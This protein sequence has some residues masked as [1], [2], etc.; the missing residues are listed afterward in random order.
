[1]KGVKRKLTQR[2]LE[3]EVRRVEE[4]GISSDESNSNGEEYEEPFDDSGSS[5]HFSNE[6]DSDESVES[7]ILNLETEEPTTDPI[8]WGNGEEDLIVYD[9]TGSEGVK[10]NFDENNSPIDVFLT[11]FDETLFNKIVCWTNSKAVKVSKNL[12]RKS[13]MH[14]WKNVDKTELKKFLGLCIAMGNVQMP[15]IKCYWSKQEIYYHPLF[16]KTMGRNRFEM[17]LRCMCFYNENDDLSKRMHKISNITEHILENIRKVYYPGRN[18]SIDEALLLW[19]ERL[20]FRQYIPN[21]AAKY[22][23]KLYELCT[24]DGYVLN[25]II[26]SGKGTV[27]QGSRGHASSVVHEIMQPYLNKGHTIYV[28]NYYSSVELAE[29]MLRNRTHVVGTLRNN[30]KGNPTEVIGKKLKKGEY[31]WKRRENIV[32]GKWR[33]KRDV[34]VI[35]TCHKFELTPVANRNGNEKMKPNIVADYNQFMSGVD[36]ADQMLSY[37][38]TPRKTIRWYL[39]LFF[40]LLDICIWNACWLY[41]KVT[42]KNISY[43]QFRNEIITALIANQQNVETKKTPKISHFLKKLEKRVRCR[44]CSQNKKRKQTWYICDSC[45]DEKNNPVGLCVKCFPVYHNV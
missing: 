26:Y 40:H 4:H 3:E 21:K 42:K 14:R 7:E 43:L 28:D 25:I 1:M 20:I 17:I 13:N 36:R 38:S 30:R 23:I 29:D 27:Q 45:T 18:L 32:V 2:E 6:S 10:I 16:T 41:K 31:I 35:S 19:R 39:K 37:Y 44:V 11:L 5:V 24:P 22:G 12:K 33:D 34:L 8:E 9:F 15:S